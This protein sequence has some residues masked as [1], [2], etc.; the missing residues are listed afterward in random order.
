MLTSSNPYSFTSN[1][2]TS[3]YKCYHPVFRAMQSSKTNAM[4][5]YI[6]NPLLLGGKPPRPNNIVS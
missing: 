4:L 2:Q 3:H 6:E 5:P 1:I